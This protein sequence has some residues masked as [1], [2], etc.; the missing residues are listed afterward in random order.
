M[1][2][3]ITLSS[4]VGHAP[5]NQT[6]LNNVGYQ[7]M[8]DYTTYQ[9]KMPNGTS[10]TFDG[11]KFET[12]WNGSTNYM[13]SN[14]GNLFANSSDDGLR[15]YA[16]SSM[17]KDRKLYVQ[18]WDRFNSNLWLPNVI[19]FTG[20]WQHNNRQYHP[21]LEMVCFH[22]MDK[23][24]NRGGDYRPTEALRSYSGGSHYWEYGNG[25]Q[26]DSGSQWWIGYQ[27]PANRRQTIYNSQL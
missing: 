21:R 23:D 18:Y 6:A 17:G 4:Q 16:S 15:L 19:G 11:Y 14:Q 10:E 2:N 3:L 20:M 7:P 9:D 8:L 26:H 1:A 25:G 5:T 24:G 12:D 13:R 27:L 22:Y